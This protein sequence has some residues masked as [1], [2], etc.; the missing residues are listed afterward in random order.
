ME[1]H[2][3]QK[4]TS[5]ILRNSRLELNDP[6]F[7]DLLMKRIE[8]ERDRKIRLQLRLSYSLITAA[9]GLLVFLLVWS[10][11]PDGFRVIIETINNP[12]SSALVTESGYFILPLLILL[13]FKKFLDSR[14]KY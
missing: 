4:G 8:R 2:Q 1:D 12:D 9:I 5:E 13:V 11:N 7:T 10:I 6:G 14:I 3:I